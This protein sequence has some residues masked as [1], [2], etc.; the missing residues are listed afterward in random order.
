[1][2]GK[3]GGQAMS[4]VH[5]AER[6]VHGIDKARCVLQEAAGYFENTERRKDL[7]NMA[8]HIMLLLYTVDGLLHNANSDLDSAVKAYFEE[9]KAARK[10]RE[11]CEH[12]TPSQG[13]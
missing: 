1:M 8:N 13:G 2:H 6:S 10:T 7:P 11:I 3:R 5:A 4:I 12:K 9:R